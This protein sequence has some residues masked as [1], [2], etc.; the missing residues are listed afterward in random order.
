ML[1]ISEINEIVHDS[2]C[3]PYVF[4]VGCLSCE[5]ISKTDVVRPTC[6]DPAHIPYV[7]AHLW[8][9]DSRTGI[10]GWG[11]G[12]KYPILPTMEKGQAIRLCLIA[13][14]SFAEHEVGEH[15]EYQGKRIYD[16]HTPVDKLMEI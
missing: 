4:I 16:P 7:Q 1:T 2:V 10:L 13:A 9:A 11:G 6:T 5:L 8:R 3:D 12:A 14:K 15:F